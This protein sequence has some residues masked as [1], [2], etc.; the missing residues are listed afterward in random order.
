MV[1]LLPQSAMSLFAFTLISWE[2]SG[3]GITRHTLF[4]SVAPAY[5][6]AASVIG[7][8]LVDAVLYSAVTLLIDRATGTEPLGAAVVSGVRRAYGRARAAWLRTRTRGAPLARTPFLP[9]ARC[10][11]PDTRI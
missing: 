3:L 11:Q 10:V 4:R 8:L 6:S 2:A 5:F 9:A 1:C 7:M